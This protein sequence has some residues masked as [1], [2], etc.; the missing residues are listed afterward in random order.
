MVIVVDVA[1]SNPLKYQPKGT[2]RSSFFFSEFLTIQRKKEIEKK[3]QSRVVFKKQLTIF[4]VPK[5]TPREAD[6][7]GNN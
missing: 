5:I 3:M 7:W 6:Y 1:R 4:A 2:L